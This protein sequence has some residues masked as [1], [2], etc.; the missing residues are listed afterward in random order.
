M[1]AVA[2]LATI[3][4]TSLRLAIGFG[5]FLAW[6]FVLSF[7]V[8]VTQSDRLPRLAALHLNLAFLF[9]HAAGVV[10]SVAA[11][12]A[13][14]L[15]RHARPMLI[16][17]ALL[18]IASLVMPGELLSVLFLLLGLLSAP[19]TVGVGLGLVDLVPRGEQTRVAGVAAVLCSTIFY[20]VGT[21]NQPVGLTVL[22][23]AS[24]ALLA[25]LA[26]PT[27]T[28]RQVRDV[29]DGWEASAGVRLYVVSLAGFGAS[30][31]LSVG[32]LL[33]LAYPMVL[34]EGSES[35]LSFALSS[36]LALLIA[37]L[38]EG[39]RRFIL[40]LVAPVTLGIS[41]T[42]FVVLD[43]CSACAVVRSLARIGVITAGIFLWTSLVDLMVWLHERVTLA[44]GLGVIV[45][46]LA[47]GLAVG[48][49]LNGEAASGRLVGHGLT[50]TALLTAGAIGS[51]VIG[52]SVWLG[53]TPSGPTGPAAGGR[54]GT[55]E[56][57]PASKLQGRVGDR[58]PIDG[59]RLAI[60]LKSFGLSDREV[61]VAFRLLEG[62]KWDQITETL[63]ISRNTLKTHVRNIYRKTGARNRHELLLA[64]LDER[65]TARG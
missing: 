44:L 15:I 38:A 17:C 6:A 46:S 41:L 4:P 54:D 45:L 47:F 21:W 33:G 36:V 56:R 20:V 22:V 13:G 29:G 30:V 25:G 1:G 24:G 23:I 40:A 52:R 53:M 58:L 43:D 2:R 8:P 16:L 65:M 9:G 10:V 32:L 59:D 35:L 27:P 34:R 7:L 42:F 31:F 3:S 18:T 61:E 37:A 11:G 57:R 50:V 49:I 26:V 14:Q 28:K 39:R 62:Q 51:I 60:R 63:G 48:R 19:F 64:A 5:W 12:W 55:C